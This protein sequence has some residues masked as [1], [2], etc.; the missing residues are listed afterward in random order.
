MGQSFLKGKNRPS[1][2]SS[3]RSFQRPTLNVCQRSLMSDGRWCSNY[4]VASTSTYGFTCDA[5]CSL[6][7]P[8]SVLHYP[9]SGTPCFPIGCS[10]WFP[11]VARVALEATGEAI[12]SFQR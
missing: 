3:T 4:V 8:E 11:I 7:L 1:K 12:F 5:S 9:Q 2:I 6:Q 10:L